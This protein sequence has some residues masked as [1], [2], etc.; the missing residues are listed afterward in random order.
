MDGSQRR[1]RR[2]I[3]AAV[4]KNFI[5]RIRP[6]DRFGANSKSDKCL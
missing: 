5:N 6:A 3:D 4:V 1:K 2:K